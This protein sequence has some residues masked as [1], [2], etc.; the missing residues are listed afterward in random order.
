MKIKGIFNY[1]KQQEDSLHCR[2]ST[3]GILDLKYPQASIPSDPCGLHF[4]NA[5]I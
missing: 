5:G 3:F 2:F 4:L 1:G